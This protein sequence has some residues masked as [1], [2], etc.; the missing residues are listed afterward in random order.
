MVATERVVKHSLTT[1]RHVCPRCQGQVIRCTDREPTCLQCGW[2][3]YGQFGRDGRLVGPY[4][5]RRRK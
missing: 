2:V 1:E 5:M 3:N 4:R